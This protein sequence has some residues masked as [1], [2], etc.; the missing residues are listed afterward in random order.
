MYAV[1]GFDDGLGIVIFG[2]A[3]AIGLSMLGAQQGGESPSF[4]SLIG[5]PIIEIL[6]SLGVGAA[7]ALL[8]SLLARK[9]RS[10]S[11]ILILLTAFLFFC[12]GIAVRLGFSFILAN[13]MIGVLVVNTQPSPFVQRIREVLSPLMPFLFLLF[14]ALAGANLHVAALPALGLVGAAYIVARSAG[15]IGGATLGALLG[16]AEKKLRRLAGI[17]ILSQAGVAIGLSLVIKEEFAAFGERGADIGT[18]ILTTVTA[19]SIVFEVIG[20]IF[21]RIALKRAGEIGKA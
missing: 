12:T 16:R 8:F 15:K 14:F 5:L 6:A 18:A 9:R 4:V 13:M 11:E 1:V 17:G 2:F 20:P 3:L 19:T 7:L 10:S 21:A